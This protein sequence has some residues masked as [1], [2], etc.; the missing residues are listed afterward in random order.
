MPRARGYSPY[1]SS[2]EQDQ[3]LDSIVENS[4]THGSEGVGVFDLDGCLF[5]TRFCQ[6]HIFWEYALHTGAL[7]LYSVEAIHF[8]DWDLGNTMRN[9]GIEESRI[10]ELLEG[11]KK[12]WFDRFFTSRYV[13]FDHAM[14]GAVDLVNRCRSAG[15]KIVYLTGRDETMRAGTEAS[16]TGFGFPLDG[17]ECRL[18]VKPD[19]ATDDTE[20]KDAA[21]KTIAGMAQPVIFLDNEPANVNKFYERYPQAQVVFVE[22]DHSPRPDEPDSSLPWLRSFSRTGG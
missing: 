22:T 14:P 21:L 5:D 3:L 11:L 12:F 4:K 2:T 19:F 8:K 10:G 17:D 15:L 20:F 16:L 1:E 6:V 7:E 13:Q 18:L 9:A